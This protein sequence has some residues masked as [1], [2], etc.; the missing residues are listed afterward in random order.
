MINKTNMNNELKDFSDIPISVLEEWINLYDQLNK[1]INSK[2]IKINYD[3][4]RETSHKI[5][6]IQIDHTKLK[7]IKIN[8]AREILREIKINNILNQ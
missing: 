7:E 2:K 6:D 5:R 3:L 1:L 8:E 4:Y